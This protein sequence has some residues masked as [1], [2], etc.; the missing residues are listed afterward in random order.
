M[1][2]PTHW[3][4]RYAPHSTAAERNKEHLSAAPSAAVVA[5]FDGSSGSDAAARRDAA[6]AQVY[7]GNGAHLL[8][9]A[10]DA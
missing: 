4:S 2:S 1:W 3:Q 5:A 7:G 10:S 6:A 9:S 8:F